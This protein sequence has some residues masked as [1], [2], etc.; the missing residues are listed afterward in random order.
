M[1]KNRGRKV[2]AKDL[3]S[4]AMAKDRGRKVKA[5]DLGPKAKDSRCQ[6]QWQKSKLTMITKFLCIVKT[7]QTPMTPKVCPTFSFWADYQPALRKYLLDRRRSDSNSNNASIQLPEES[8]PRTTFKAKDKENDL[9]HEAKA[10]D[11]KYQD[12]GITSLS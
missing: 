7:W 9:G 11:S 10:K 4:K 12:Q 6:G 8:R 2:K 5:K 3:R 1:A